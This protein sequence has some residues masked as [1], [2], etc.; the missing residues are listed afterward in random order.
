MRLNPK[1]TYY[2]KEKKVYYYYLRFSHF[3]AK[4]AHNPS[5]WK[6]QY[7][8]LGTALIS[9]IPYCSKFIVVHIYFLTISTPDKVSRLNVS[10]KRK[11]AVTTVSSDPPNICRMKF[12]SWFSRIQDGQNL[13]QSTSILYQMENERQQLSPDVI[14]D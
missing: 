3:E 10:I 14:I 5:L 9:P 12:W 7:W 4:G 1:I 6:S 13:V 8:E 2:L 11:V